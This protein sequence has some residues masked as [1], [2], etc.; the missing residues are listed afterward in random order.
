[1][2]LAE[3]NEV[4]LLTGSKLTEDELAVFVGFAHNLITDTLSNKPGLSAGRL[5]LIETYLAAHF[6][7]VSSP[8]TRSLGIGE[9]RIEYADQLNRA[10]V[11]T[12]FKLTRFG[13]Q[14]MA[15]DTTGTLASISSGNPFLMKT[16]NSRDL[17]R[18][19]TGWIR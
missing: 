10:D 18:E 11:G 7:E 15:L 3:V 8:P 4:A 17:N 19:F 5:K 2:A 13:Q 12:G 14:A 16:S 9:L 1:M 6:I